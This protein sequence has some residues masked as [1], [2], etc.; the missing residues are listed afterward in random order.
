MPSLAESEA[1]AGQARARYVDVLTGGLDPIAESL[2][3]AARDTLLKPAER[4]VQTRR[5]EGV[6]ALL[7]R[8]SSWVRRIGRD[9]QQALQF[10][11][12]TLFAK[13][14]PLPD[15]AQLVTGMTLVD[16]DTIEREILAS[17]L[18]AAII[19]RSNWEFNDLRS[20]LLMLEQ[21]ND[22]DERDV[23]RCGV[24]ARIVTEAWIAENMALQVWQDQQARIHDEFSALV[25]EALHE[26]N[27]WLIAQGVMPEID[28]RPFIRRSRGRGSGAGGAGAL[29]QPVAEPTDVPM[30]PMAHQS[31]NH[32]MQQPMGWRGVPQATSHDATVMEPADHF[33]TRPVPMARTRTPRSEAQAVL[34]RLTG[35]MGEVAGPG[36]GSGA[37]SGAD[38]RYAAAP[39]LS[40]RLARAM[41]EVQVGLGDF[42]RN[43]ATVDVAAIPLLRQELEQQRTVLREVAA[44][45][46]ER[47]TIEIVALMFQSI[48][49]EDRLPTAV[50]IWFARLQMPVLRVAVTEPDFFATLDHP[51]R[52][53]IDRMGACVMG[54]EGRTEATSKALEQEIRR[55]VQVVEAYPDTG[56]KVFQ[57]VLNEFERFLESY[58]R[59]QN[60]ATRKGVSLAQQLEQRETMAIQYTIELRK[61]LEGVPVQDEIRKFL[62]E[63]WAD[64][65][66]TV[67]VSHGTGSEQARAMKR[68][69]SD[70]IWSAGAKIN[71]EERASVLRRLPPLLKSL[72]EG[73]AMSG[74]EPARQDELVKALNDAL[75]AGFTAKAAPIPTAQLMDLTEQLESLESMMPDADLVEIDDAL[76][77]DLPGMSSTDLEVVRDG[78]DEPLE[79]MLAWARE[80][81]VGSWFL[82]AHGERHEPLQLAWYGLRRQLALFVAPNGQCKLF[83]TR[84][85]AA[86]LQAGLMQPAQE[87][88]L[89]IKATREALE[90][91][92]DGTSSLS[93]HLPG[94]TQ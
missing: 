78:G 37:G 91:L 5:A 52:R 35:L 48:L 43:P 76:M 71:R 70:L 32:A 59:E 50:R 92:S 34:D 15:K 26:A 62:F 58:F 55:I 57:T 19:D 61:M 18:G 33:I 1:L 67:G 24:V 41:N 6:R 77:R 84:R 60:E 27:S 45:P 13:A 75:A 79:A 86:Y 10:G 74:L 28:L 29:T 21:H 47:T 80:L 90:A 9:L 31:A 4:S 44:T 25:E 17:R 63:V 7:E 54:F 89:T 42:P 8:R 83:Q 46:E 72:R 16:D 2:L 69:A 64:V 40:P 68:V 14:L 49:A 56:R 87:E 81:Q 53:L 22:L 39:A 38:A 88:A 11:A 73:M 94:L 36:S 30:H 12:G 82:L 23:C 65:L 93:A 20:R 3:D 51:A 66:A 85:L